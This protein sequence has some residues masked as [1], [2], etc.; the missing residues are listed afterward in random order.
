LGAAICRTRRGA[1]AA[2]EFFRDQAHEQFQ[3]LRPEAQ[4]I[5]RQLLKGF[6]E[7][8]LY[9]LTDDEAD[10]YNALRVY[11]APKEQKVMPVQD[12]KGALGALLDQLPKDGP[13]KCKPCWVLTDTGG[14]KGRRGFRQLV[15]REYAWLQRQVWLRTST[16][17]QYLTLNQALQAADWVGRLPHQGRRQTA[18]T[19]KNLERIRAVLAKNPALSARQIAVMLSRG[20]GPPISYGSVRKLLKFLVTE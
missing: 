14:L 7:A 3:K 17:E 11:G 16:P 2:V 18:M 19:H 4:K 13:D 8:L 5:I 10:L 15:V 9:R 12:R 20:A 6:D 1:A